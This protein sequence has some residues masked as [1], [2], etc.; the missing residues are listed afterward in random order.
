MDGD[1][2]AILVAIAVALLAALGYFNRKK[3]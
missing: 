3:R 1:L 2:I